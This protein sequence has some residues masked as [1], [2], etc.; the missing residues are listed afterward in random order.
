VWI[1]GSAH[2]LEAA[3]SAGELVGTST[4]DGKGALATPT[5]TVSIAIDVAAMST[6]GGVLVYG[7][8]EDDDGRL[9]VLQP[10]ELAG[11]RERIDQIVQTSIT[12]P[13]IIDIRP[14]VLD[15]PTKGYVAVVVPQS[16][17][18][19]H[20]VTA[21]GD[22]RYY[23]R[24]PK[25]NRILT[26]GEIA[27]LYA[28]RSEWERGAAE[29]LEE[30]I[31]RSP[32]PMQGW[33]ERAG[34]MHAIARP[35]A[36]DDGIL[37]RAGGG[38]LAALFHGGPLTTEMSASH[39]SHIEPSI[40]HA[41]YMSRRGN[42]GWTI[43]TVDEDVARQV[44]T[45]RSTAH[46]E[47]DHD[48]VGYLF[49]GR[50]AELWQEHLVL[51]ESV[52]ACNLAE[53][54]AAMGGIYDRA[55]Y[56]GYVDVGVAVLNIEGAHSSLLGE[57]GLTFNPITYKAADHRRTE[58]VGASELHGAPQE[59]ARRLLSRLFEAMAG[60]AVDPFTGERRDDASLRL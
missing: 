44:R 21:G 51:F 34:Y 15:D 58:R 55:G 42:L 43:S 49:M 7:L 36:P 46:L 30:A 48:G 47:L 33:D 40:S 60:D 32:S 52:I 35:L 45:A 10:F 16:A 53:F 37:D 11:V 26:E 3:A 38:D 41:N 2:E 8:A 22:L 24:G 50:A 23:G 5:D 25:G 27:R 28:R 39:A 17:R 19:P 57:E 20:Q 56:F 4:F 29:L 9:T 18:A 6:D 31:A 13:P 54:L 14:L 59:V 12:E 1:P